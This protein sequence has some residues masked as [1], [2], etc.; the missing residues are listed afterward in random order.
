MT[1]TLKNEAGIDV[2]VN[3]RHHLSVEKSDDWKSWWTLLSQADLH[4]GR[5][6]IEF[7][8]QAN[9]NRSSSFTRWQLKDVKL[10][11]PFS[12][13]LI[14][15]ATF[16]GSS[17]PVPETALGDPF[18]TPFNASVTVPFTTAGPGQVRISVFNLM[19]QQVRVLHDGWT[20][21]G[22]HQAH[23]D[24]RSD[25]GAEAASGIYWALLRTEQFAQSTRLVLIR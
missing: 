20:E 18:P 8:N 10:W 24:G 6:V 3:G 25:S 16:L 19:G 23:W 4:S 21:A 2:L 22:V 1:W 11:K 5:N 7:R 17:R 14:A 9:Q 13:K 15:G 12:A